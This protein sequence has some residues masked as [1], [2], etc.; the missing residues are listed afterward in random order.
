MRFESQ[1][2]HNYE[3]ANENTCDKVIVIEPRED[4][5]VTVSYLLQAIGYPP[6]RI[7]RYL[8]ADDAT[9]VYIR[10][11]TLVIANT[12]SKSFEQMH[13]KLH[14][15]PVLHINDQLELAVVVN[16]FKKMEKEQVLKDSLYSQRL[17]VALQ[18]A[19]TL[20]HLIKSMV[21]QDI[22]SC[23]NVL[24]SVTDSVFVVNAKWKFTHVNKQ[25]EHRFGR[26]KKRLLGRSIWKMFPDMKKLSFYSECRRAVKA[27]QN[28][29][30]EEYHPGLDMWLSV[31]AYPGRDSLAIYLA[32]IT[33]L[34]KAVA[35][36]RLNH[37]PFI[38]METGEDMR[39]FQ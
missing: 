25:F 8:S 14:C 36:D 7:I 10:D 22:L 38:H 30:F 28:V 11:V 9:D 19:S 35:T 21:P 3:G 5:Y 17:I 4:M 6:A 39:Y 15:I 37:E 32:D 13:D 1:S 27:Q 23:E 29:R 24:E 20:R 12:L 18:H 31:R 26:G 16:P 33:R 2:E 34:K